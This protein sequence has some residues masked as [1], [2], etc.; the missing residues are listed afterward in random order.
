MTPTYTEAFR[1]RHKV[2]GI[3]APAVVRGLEGT[4]LIRCEG[5]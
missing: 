2:A 5:H 3:E 1:C 4:T